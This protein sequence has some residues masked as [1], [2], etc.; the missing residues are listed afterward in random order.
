MLAI[1]FNSQ[2]DGRTIR[3]G[4]TSL[5]LALAP[6]TN[7]GVGSSQSNVGHSQKQQVQHR[8]ALS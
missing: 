1:I 8:L 5:A 2:F 4:T 7:I 3:I 6:L